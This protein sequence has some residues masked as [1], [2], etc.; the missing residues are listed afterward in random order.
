MTTTKVLY[1]T[2]D[3]LTYGTVKQLKHSYVY[4]GLTN[5]QADSSAT[6][7]GNY[8]GVVNP[9]AGELSNNTTGEKWS[10]TNGF[11]PNLGDGGPG[12]MAFCGHR[13][14]TKK[15][16]QWYDDNGPAQGGLPFISQ[17]RYAASGG[18]PGPDMTDTGIYNTTLYH[19]S[20]VNAIRWGVMGNNR[21]TQSGPANEW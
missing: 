16:W 11:T 4:S 1:T 18:S 3:G 21:V 6:Y 13:D 8:A 9:A 20:G 17:A 5:S 15:F 14:E 19:Q 2:D 7:Q 12:K 10:H